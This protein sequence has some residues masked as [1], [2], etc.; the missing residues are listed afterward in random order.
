MVGS[1]LESMEEG[2]RKL[3][4]KLIFDVLMSG[5]NNSLTPE[6]QLVGLQQNFIF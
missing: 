5:N 6:I 2:Q 1:E 3:A 4:K